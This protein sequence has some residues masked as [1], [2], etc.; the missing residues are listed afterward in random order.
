MMKNKNYILSL[1]VALALTACTNNDAEENNEKVKVP[2]DTSTNITS[3]IIPFQEEGG[4]ATRVNMAGDQFETNDMIRLRIVA[5]YSTNYTEYGESTWGGG[6]YDNWWLL[7]WGGDKANWNQLKSTNDRVFDLNGD[8]AKSD[9]TALTYLVQATPYVFTAT[10][11]TE[12][13]HYIIKS[14]SSSGTV[15][16]SFSN[17][18]K[19]DQRRPED[20][21]ASNVLW[22]QQFMQTGT[23][24]VRLS[25][26]HKMAA[27][28]I[29]VSE[30]A[31]ELTGSDEIILTL[32]GMPDIDQ[33]E[34]I[35]GNY[36]AAAI[37]SKNNYGESTRSACK[38]E[39]NGKVLGIA[40]IDETQKKIIQKPFSEL[41]Q[42]G[43]YTAYKDGNEFYL[44]IPPYTL[45]ASAMPRL[46]LRQGSKRWSAPLMQLADGETSFEF[47]SGK[48][49][50]VTMK[51]LVDPTPDPDDD[52]NPD[53]GDNE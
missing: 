49:Y 18:F 21:K 44:I 37:K 51:K 28:R 17:V 24:N 53:D 39:Q 22:A 5:P 3:E 16:T 7:T 41:P 40:V 9:A 19:A 43:V 15:I 27:L 11:W 38:K 32:E 2:F 14:A 33:Q 4:A 36:Y 47:E 42:N 35:I 50:K 34:V 10:T 20:Y 52:P 45:S 12:E 13:I 29:D 26:E 25:F 6:T 30:F 1:F 8:F 48:R 46:W 31:S 23:G